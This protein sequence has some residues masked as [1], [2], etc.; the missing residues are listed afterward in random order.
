MANVLVE[1]CRNVYLKASVGLPVSDFE[2]LLAADCMR[3]QDVARSD[4]D[5]EHNSICSAKPQQHK[6][7]GKTAH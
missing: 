4:P 6:K 2:H 5:P 1:I 3:Y 7:T